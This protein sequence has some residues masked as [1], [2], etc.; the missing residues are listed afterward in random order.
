M[1][2]LIM[3]DILIQKKQA[4]FSLFYILIIIFA[5]QSMEVGTFAAGVVAFTYMMVM[6]SCAYEDK[7]KADIMLNSLPIKRNYIVYIKYV[8]V[9]VFFLV[10]TLA[11]VVFTSILKVIR[12]PIEINPLTI[13]EFIGGVVAVSIVS[14]IYLP[15]FF[16]VGYIKSK[17][18]CLFLFIG[19]FFSVSFIAN[20]LK[21]FLNSDAIVGFTNFIQLQSDGA[22]ALI[23]TAIAILFMAVSYFVSV[24]FY[25]RRE[26]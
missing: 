21:E 6:T 12:F 20:F 4:V 25:K 18:L 1:L 23:I 26:F 5:F 8:S 13:E 17:V 2:N 9:A 11:Y 7:N 24:M 15:A 3:K 22:I 10:G 19:F 16:K 14:G